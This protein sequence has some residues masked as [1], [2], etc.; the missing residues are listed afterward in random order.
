MALVAP[1]TVRRLETWL[2]GVE[3]DDGTTTSSAGAI[4][5]V[6]MGVCLE[7]LKSCGA[8]GARRT[9]S[10]LGILKTVGIVG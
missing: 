9:A 1:N 10:R 6:A 5:E 7:R 4:G 8:R 2:S 3:R